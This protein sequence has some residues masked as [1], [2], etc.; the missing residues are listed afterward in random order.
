MR[1]I[2]GSFKC[3]LIPVVFKVDDSIYSEHPVYLSAA[4]WAEGA[5]AGAPVPL[6]QN[7]G[8]AN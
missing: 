4:F 5:L 6:L 2:C 3:Y 7:D 8:T 1:I